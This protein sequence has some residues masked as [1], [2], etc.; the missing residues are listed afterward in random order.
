M[1][2]VYL[3]NIHKSWDDKVYPVNM[4]QWQSSPVDV[5]PANKVSAPSKPD[6]AIFL[7][8]PA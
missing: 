4:W 1:E 6:I 7:K 8:I 5:V 2:N 3:C